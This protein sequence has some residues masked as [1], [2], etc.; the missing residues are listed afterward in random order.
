MG[1]N[2]GHCPSQTGYMGFH[3]VVL[4]HGIVAPNPVDDGAFGQNLISVTHQQFQNLRFFQLE[5]GLVVAA[6]ER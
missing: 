1:L 5:P 2:V 4:S 6:G 3:M